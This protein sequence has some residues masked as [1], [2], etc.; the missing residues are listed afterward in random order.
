MQRPSTATLGLAA[1]AL[2]LC[3]LVF[4]FQQRPDVAAGPEPEPEPVAHTIL[5]SG[6]IVKKMASGSASGS[7]AKRERLAVIVPFRDGADAL[8]QG[9]GRMQQAREFS[10]YM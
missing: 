6:D 1:A 8:S 2:A 5:Y 4:V 10:D 9:D 7:R 3:L